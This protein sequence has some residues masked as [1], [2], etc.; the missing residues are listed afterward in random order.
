MPR[1]DV[2]YWQIL[3]QKSVETG[4]AV[5]LSFSTGTL[6]APN[7]DLAPF[8]VAALRPPNSMHKYLSCPISRLPVQEA[9]TILRVPERLPGLHPLHLQWFAGMIDVPLAAVSAPAAGV[10]RR[11]VYPW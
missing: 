10:G 11:S 7:A 4:F 8:S 6:N 1:A 2:G 5:L 9:D 3:L